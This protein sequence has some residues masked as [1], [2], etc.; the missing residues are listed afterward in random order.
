M[1]FAVA[2]IDVQGIQNSLADPQSLSI[3]SPSQSRYSV[4]TLAVLKQQPWSQLR[5]HLRYVHA[6]VHQQQPR[7][8]EIAR[9]EQWEAAELD[10]CVKFLETTFGCTLADGKPCSTLIPL[11]YYVEYR[12]Q[13]SF[14]AESSWTWSFWEM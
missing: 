1:Y 9:L 12:A 5:H 8:K 4:S 11:Q 6:L 7:E 14:S 3:G 10:K 13:V 2:P